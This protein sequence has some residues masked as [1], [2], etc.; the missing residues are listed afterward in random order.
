MGMS[1]GISF[2]SSVNNG[3]LSVLIRI[4]YENFHLT[5]LNIVF[6]QQSEEFPRYAKTS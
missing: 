5:S 1:L 2:Q 4:K 6:L 3:M